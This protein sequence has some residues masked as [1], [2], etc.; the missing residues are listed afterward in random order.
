MNRFFELRSAIPVVF[1]S[2]LIGTLAFAETRTEPAQTYPLQ[3]G[4]YLSL[5]NIN[6]D[7]T[8]EGWKKKEVSIT[9]TKKGERKDL[10][11]MKIVVDVDKYEGKDWIHIETEYLES[12]GGLL[13]F[14]KG[15]GSI[16]YTIKAPSDAILEDIEMV[17]GNLKVSGI[18]DSLSLST[19]NGSITATGM[20]GSAWVETVN[21]N[22][23]LSFDKMSGGQTVDLESVNGGISLRIP[24]KANARVEAETLNGNVSNEFGLT[25]EKG[26]WIGRSIEGLLGPGGARITLETVNGS[27]DIKKR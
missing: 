5:E 13:D 21:G 7:V 14:L 18:T 10:D 26:E 20:T 27:I 8:I 19:V 17:N 4:G 3:A 16:D 22:L 23:D 12:A 1:S 15:A 24:A 9:A 25:V 2:I 6:G 11:R